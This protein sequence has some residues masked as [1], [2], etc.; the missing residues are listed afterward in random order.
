LP[1]AAD[2]N[3]EGLDLDAAALE[4]LLSIDREGWKA[5]MASIGEYLDSFG[6]RTPH[7]LKAERAK[8]A[9]RLA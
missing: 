8:I 1:K 5:E 9:A 6:D 7:A 3:V 4:Q 2:L